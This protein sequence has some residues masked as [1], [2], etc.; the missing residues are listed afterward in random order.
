MMTPKC[1]ETG[2]IR[3]GHCMLKEK[4]P[5]M[6]QRFPLWQGRQKQQGQGEQEQGQ[7]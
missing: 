6:A 1:A 7:G 2:K 5:V 4:I 3:L